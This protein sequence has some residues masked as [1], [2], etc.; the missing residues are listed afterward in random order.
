MANDLDDI[1]AEVGQLATPPLDS[2]D[3]EI[4]L[5]QSQEVEATPL[6]IT[7]VVNGGDCGKDECKQ[8]RQQLA[9]L[10]EKYEASLST[11]DKLEAARQL[12]AAMPV[13]E[14]HTIQRGEEHAIR[15]IA[16]NY[17]VPVSAIERLNPGVNV[18]HLVPG[19]KLRIK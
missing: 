6:P 1:L 18:R 3:K 12:A 2:T 11:I 7:S 8:L 13:G 10:T 16:K 15:V 4:E 9:T 19:N 17:G 5:V 14:E